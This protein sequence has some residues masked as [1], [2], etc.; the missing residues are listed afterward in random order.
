MFD[1]HLC[2][3]SRVTCKMN[4]HAHL[5]HRFSFLW[6]RRFLFISK[7]NKGFVWL[8]LTSLLWYRREGK[9][10]SDDITKT[11]SFTLPEDTIQKAIRLRTKYKP[12]TVF[13]WHW[14]ACA[15]NCQ[16]NLEI[17]TWGLEGVWTL[18]QEIKAWQL[19]VLNYIKMYDWRKRSIIFFSCLKKARTKW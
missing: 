16:K 7:V 3:I 4:P 1:Q 12:V 14:L 13:Y 15:W 6:V 5:P 18:T 8:V 19:G 11:N 17:W 9:E 2:T 10:L